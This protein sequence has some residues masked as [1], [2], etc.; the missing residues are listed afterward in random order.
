[1]SEQISS[2]IK[3]QYISE[4]SLL[5]AGGFEH[6]DPRYGIIA[7]GPKSYDPLDRHPSSVRIGFI[8]TAE[9]IET[10]QNWLQRGA[11]GV[12]GDENY[13]RFPG[14]QEDRGFRSTLEFSE[15]WNGQIYKTEVDEIESIKNRRLRFEQFL[16]LL[17]EKLKLLTDKDRPPEYLVLALTDELYE[18]CR[19]AKYRDGNEIIQRDFRRAFKSL[20]MKYRIPTQ[21]LK[22]VTWEDRTGDVVSKIY[23]NFFTGLYFKAGGFPWAPIGLQAGTCFIGVS[24]YHPLGVGSSILQTSLI[25]AF[26]E[27]GEG[28]VLRGYEFEWDPNR[29]GSRSP[30]LDAEIS[31]QLINQTLDRYSAEMGQTPQR[32]VVHK[33]S[34]FW[35]EERAGM[36]SA[37]KKRVQ[38]FDL[39]A[40]KY[41]DGV[42]LVP[43]NLYPPLRGTFF[44]LGDLDYMYTTG[45]VPQIGLYQ[46]VH[47]PSP[48][49]IA[50]HIGQDTPRRRL[51]EEILILTKLNWNSSVLGG[52]MPITIRFARLVGEILREVPRDREPLANYKYYM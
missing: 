11:A 48:I 7:S 14:F 5:F 21:I 13:L 27:H 42:R 2:L 20:A 10:A 12:D 40:L 49:E 4:P 36:T 32:V 8:G 39:L 9:S 43:E 38:S 1:M 18:K 28:L 47:V 50:D 15:S 30:H 6:A 26:D 19:V 22:Q 44:S 17:D 37:L 52:S 16:N 29:Q 34:R 45:Y 24:F 31:E 23:W 25:Q 35:P 33:T 51:I 3:S 46:G 41:Q